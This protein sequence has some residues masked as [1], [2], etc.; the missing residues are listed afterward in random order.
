MQIIQEIE[1]SK[2]SIQIFMSSFNQ[3]HFINILSKKHQEGLNVSIVLKSD[4]DI[5]PNLGSSFLEIINHLPKKHDSLSFNDFIIIDNS[6]V[7]VSINYINGQFAFVDDN[8]LTLKNDYESLKRFSKELSDLKQIL[9]ENSNDYDIGKVIEE[10]VKVLEKKEK[11]NSNIKGIPTGF[12]D[13]DFL[14]DGWQKSE[15]I[16]LAS[17]P[18]AGKSSWLLSSIRN[19]VTDF[20]FRAAVFSLELSKVNLITRLFALECEIS[21]SK[22]LK[23]SINNK[24]LEHLKYRTNLLRDTPLFIQEA[25]KINL[26][27]LRTKIQY[28]KRTEKIDLV[29]IDYLQLIQAKHFNQDITESEILKGLKSLAREFNLPIIVLYQFSPQEGKVSEFKGNSYFLPEIEVLVNSKYVDTLLVLKDSWETLPEIQ[30]EREQKATLNV[31]KT[32]NGKLGNITLNF[33]PSYGKFFSLDAARQYKN[34][35]EQLPK[36]IQATNDVRQLKN[37]G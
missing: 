30:L 16:V 27:Q 28:L 20:D 22:L 12:L 6:E 24:E 13:L 34:V 21:L 29:A 8:I 4:A 36:N 25:N 14:L 5:S 3:E 19:T 9:N 17:Q 18:N 10:R 11:L 26:P 37:V 15:L 7:I 1:K 32:S 2:S 31:I 33:I 23:G 35:P